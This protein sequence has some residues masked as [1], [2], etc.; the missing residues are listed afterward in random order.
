MAASS[1]W[2]DPP[3]VR[4]GSHGRPMTGLE[5]QIADPESGRLLAV[6]AEGELLVRGTSLM[7]HYYKMTPHECFDANGY[8]HTGDLARLD[9]TG[10]LHFLGRIKDVIKTA[11]VNVAAAEIEAVLQEHAAVKVAYVVGVPHPTRGENVAAFVVRRDEHC[12]DA[13]LVRYCRER[14]ASYKVPRHI[15]FCGEGELPVLGSGK[16]NKQAL[17]ALAVAR[18]GD[19][20]AL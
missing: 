2:D 15:V 4:A 3:A 12:G 20:D 10:H 18:T 17:R 8:F 6:D 9:A 14:L 7:L 19:R 11:G 16:V 5:F 1:R 13:E